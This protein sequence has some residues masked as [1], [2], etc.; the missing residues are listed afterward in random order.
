MGIEFKER[1]LPPQREKRHGNQVAILLLFEENERCPLHVEAAFLQDNA[2]KARTAG[3]QTSG[4]RACCRAL[5]D[6]MNFG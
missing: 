3:R 4:C 6:G 2:L 5:F 1:M